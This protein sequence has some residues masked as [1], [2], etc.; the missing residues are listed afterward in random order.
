MYMPLEWYL[1]SLTGRGNDIQASMQSQHSQPVLTSRFGEEA[2]TVSRN[3]V[4]LERRS[5]DPLPGL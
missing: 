3:L 4:S 2:S 5:C 1:P